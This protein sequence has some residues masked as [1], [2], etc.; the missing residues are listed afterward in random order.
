[1]VGHRF[2]ATGSFGAGFLALAAI[3]GAVLVLT[4][5]IRPFDLGHGPG[6]GTGSATGSCRLPTQPAVRP[7]ATAAPPS[8]IGPEESGHERAATSAV[9]PVAPG[10]EG[11][12]VA[13]PTL[14]AL[15]SLDQ[16]AR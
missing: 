12:L 6:A 15:L 3:V 8:R 1:V 10:S 7:A 14:W 2:D 11:P 13:V 9:S 5:L 4:S 16:A